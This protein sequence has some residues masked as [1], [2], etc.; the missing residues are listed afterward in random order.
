[1]YKTCNIKPDYEPLHTCMTT[2]LKFTPVQGTTVPGHRL[3]YRYYIEKIWNTL[4]YVAKLKLIKMEVFAKSEWYT[5]T[6]LIEY[7]VVKVLLSM[8]GEGQVDILSSLISNT[9]QK[10]LEFVVGGDTFYCEMTMYDYVS[11]DSNQIKRNDLSI[12]NS[13]LDT[14]IL[15]KKIAGHGQAFCQDNHIP[16]VQKL[17]VCPFI[18]L[19]VNDL[20]IGR[21][22]GIPNIANVGVNNTYSTFD[23]QISGENISL[24]VS[25]FIVLYDILTDPTNDN[26][27]KN[28]CRSAKLTN[29]LHISVFIIYF[30]NSI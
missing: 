25:D 3:M 5:E 1:M 6:S 7:F 21:T 23:Y 22:L 9:H 29:I 12:A 16:T 17:H 14:L 2:F 28:S 4:S 27:N 8:K 13:S 26:Y 19:N 18:T 20:S 15:F 30:T 24:C 11:E 10:V